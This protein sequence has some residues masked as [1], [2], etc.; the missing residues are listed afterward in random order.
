MWVSEGLS[1]NCSVSSSLFALLWT[2]RA[3][4]M[5]HW[6]SF[7]SHVF[8]ACA[9]FPV[10][11]K[12]WFSVNH[13]NAEES[14]SDAQTTTVHDRDLAFI[15]SIRETVRFN[16]PDSESEHALVLIMKQQETDH[17]RLENWLFKVVQHLKQAWHEVQHNSQSLSVYACTPAI[18]TRSDIFW[19]LVFN[20]F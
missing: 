5:P 16:V 12:H 17:R 3:N 1:T 11:K 18:K 19:K 10:F 6:E 9:Q 8:V 7:V 14:S 2:S 4:V 20:R 13:W 15:W